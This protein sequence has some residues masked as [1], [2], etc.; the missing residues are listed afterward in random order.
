VGSFS[1]DLGPTGH[2]LGGSEDL[3][4]ILRAQ[5]LGALL[6]YT[7]SVIQYHYVDVGRLT[8]TYLMKKA[9]IRSASTIGLT[10][11]P[12][13]VRIP[14]YL[15]R[16]LGEYLFFALTSLNADRRRFYLV[17]TAAALGE[18]KGYRQWIGACKRANGN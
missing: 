8:L 16:K 4:W 18:M 7:P 13:S 6:Q 17:R 14:L 1:T 12:E 11:K 10:D 15:Y 5:Q 9:Y 3:D 2:N